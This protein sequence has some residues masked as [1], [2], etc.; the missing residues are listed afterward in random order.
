VV[1]R[2]LAHYR[3]RDVACGAAANTALERH[4][5][6]RAE[7]REAWLRRNWRTTRWGRALAGVVARVIYAR[8][9]RL[10]C[11]SGVPRAEGRGGR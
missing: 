7:L 9:R 3:R 10:G 5:V 1:A 11:A 6:V 2:P 4:L 8:L